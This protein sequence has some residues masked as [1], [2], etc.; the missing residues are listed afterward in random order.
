MVAFSLLRQNMP[1]VRGQKVY[2]SSEFVEVS[3]QLAVSKANLNMIEGHLRRET[4]HGRADEKA[5][6]FFSLLFHLGY[7]PNGRC[8][9]HQVGLPLSTPRNT[10][11]QSVD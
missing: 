10:S 2:F 6:P 9:S 11:N 8:H 5:E 4:V 3:L 1:K 7:K